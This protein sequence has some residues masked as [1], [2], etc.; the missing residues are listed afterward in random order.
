MCRD[1]A[2][3]VK[4]SNT[5]LAIKMIPVKPMTKTTASCDNGTICQQGFT[6]INR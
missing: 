3:T 1:K 2:L 4:Y 6:K 5:V